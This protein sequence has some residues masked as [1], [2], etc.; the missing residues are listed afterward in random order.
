MGHDKD[1]TRRLIRDGASPEEIDLLLT[2]RVELNA[3]TSDEL[4]AW[5]EGKLE[6]HGVAKVIPDEATLTEAYRRV[7]QSA[8]LRHRFDALL[9]ASAKAVEG[10]DI[11]TDLRKRVSAALD[12]HP[13]LAWN[14][15]VR[16]IAAGDGSG[17]RAE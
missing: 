9:A 14:Q 15:A 13:E 2:R 4:V 11:P 8:W 12:E 16:S 10:L 1:I 17:E 6:G 7:R 3:F 5:I